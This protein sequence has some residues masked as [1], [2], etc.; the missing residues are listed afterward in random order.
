METSG[1]KSIN[2]RLLNNVKSFGDPGNS[3][4]S[5]LQF[6]IWKQ[7]IEERAQDEMFFTVI[8]SCVVI[9]FAL[10]IDQVISDVM[11]LMIDIFDDM[12]VK[13]QIIFFAAEP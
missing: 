12:F 10:Y 1:P 8:V 5:S 11:K 7:C 3:K 6:N 13:N 4:Q 9:V 2:E